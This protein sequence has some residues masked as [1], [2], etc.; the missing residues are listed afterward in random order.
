MKTTADLPLTEY[1]RGQL[2]H[3]RCLMRLANKDAADS[4][5]QPV[6]TISPMEKE[7]KQKIAAMS[8]DDQDDDDYSESS[9]SKHP[10]GA[11]KSNGTAPKVLTYHDA[12]DILIAAINGVKAEE[13]NCTKRGSLPLHRM[14][15]RKAHT[16]GSE[17]KR[18]LL[19]GGGNQNNDKSPNAKKKLKF[20]PKP[21]PATTKGAPM[22]DLTLFGFEKDKNYPS[23]ERKIPKIPEPKPAEPQQLWMEDAD[24]LPRQLLAMTAYHQAI[25]D[26]EKKQAQLDSLVAKLAESEE[27]LTLQQL[28]EEVEKLKPELQAAMEKVEI[29]E[30]RLKMIAGK[31]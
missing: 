26:V 7:P 4:S 16:R 25:S 17:R 10:A 1:Q 12:R 3:Y 22:I 27:P 19:P 30:T 18:S 9:S 14:S 24:V 29:A 13:L 21:A 2:A 23:G 5:L 31:V 6:E 11:K 15:A 28:K 20:T 8:V